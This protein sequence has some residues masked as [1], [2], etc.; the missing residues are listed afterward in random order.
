MKQLPSPGALALALALAPV[1]PGCKGAFF[2]RDTEEQSFR[3]SCTPQACDRELESPAAPRTPAC[4]A[5]LHAGFALAGTRLALACHACVGGE[6]FEPVGE[7]C[8]PLVCG[9]D[10]DCP[11]IGYMTTA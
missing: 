3:A 9:R 4:P 2:S 7:R 11:P 1:L 10:A 5:G 8:R 6:R